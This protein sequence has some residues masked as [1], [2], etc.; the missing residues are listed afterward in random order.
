VGEVGAQR[1]VRGAF[2]LMRKTLDLPLGAA[3][4]DKARGHQ[5]T[6]TPNIL[7]KSFAPDGEELFT[8]PPVGEVGA[9]RRVRG[10]FDLIA[11]GTGSRARS[12]AG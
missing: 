2:D 1:R 8:S 12:R 4:D 9:Q 11:K 10:A 7:Y 6:K 5:H 3:R